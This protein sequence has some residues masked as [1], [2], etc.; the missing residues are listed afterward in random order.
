MERASIDR[1][2]ITAQKVIDGVLTTIMIGDFGEL[3][4]QI[5]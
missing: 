4:E 2:E 1:V 3:D 5:P